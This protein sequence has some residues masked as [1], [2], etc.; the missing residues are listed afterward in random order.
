[1]EFFKSFKKCAKI[2][3]NRR[4]RNWIFI[5]I[6]LEEFVSGW[7]VVDEIGSGAHAALTF[8]GKK[9]R[10]PAREKGQLAANIFGNFSLPK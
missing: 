1:M 7:C 3:L 5:A 8:G 10:P 9:C 2:N 4:K 6:F